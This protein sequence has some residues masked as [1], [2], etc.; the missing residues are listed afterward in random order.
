MKD[1]DLSLD[2]TIREQR[3]HG[4]LD[5]RYNKPILVRSGLKILWKP[6]NHN[7]VK[8]EKPEP[9]YIGAHWANA[10]PCFCVQRRCRDRRD[11][12]SKHNLE[13]HL[14]TQ[15]HHITEEDV[16]KHCKE[17]DHDPICF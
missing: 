4:V 13:Y 7:F 10:D 16:L 6:G 12:Q 8:H 9:T 3:F 14:T 11:R 5:P 17:H 1:K 15:H 2:K